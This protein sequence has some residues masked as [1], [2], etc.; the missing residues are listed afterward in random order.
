[1]SYL[2]RVYFA[3]HLVEAFTKQFDQLFAQADVLAMECAFFDFAEE[4]EKSWNAVSNGGTK[5]NT[6]TESFMQEFGDELLNRLMLTHKLVV[7]EKSPYSDI[8][9]LKV[10]GMFAGARHWWAA[11][12]REKAILD[13]GKYLVEFATQSVRRDIDYS[14]QLRNLTVQHPEKT[15]LCLRGPLHY[16]TLPILL[17]ANGVNFSSHLFTHHYV[18]PLS[19]AVISRIIHGEDIENETLIRLHIYHDFAAGA[20]DYN[21]RLECSRKALAMTTTEIEEYATQEKPD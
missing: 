7:F 16:Y 8:D 11:E 15:I 5:S 20:L 19:E 4:A 10:D 18:P 3:T 13:L 17:V 21:S 14:L 1:V 12:D 9:K 2:L 6:P